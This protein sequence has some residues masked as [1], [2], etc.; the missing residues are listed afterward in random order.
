MILRFHHGWGFD[1]AFWRGVAALLPGYKLEY[2]DRGYFGEPSSP[3]P[4][5]E[6]LIAV[7]HSFGTMI[8]L[9]EP[10]ST[11][12][13]LIAFNGFDCFT[14]RKDM[15]AT[16]SRILDRMLARLSA[17]PDAVLSE[18]R[19]RC[20]DETIFARSVAEPLRRDLIALRDWDCR[21]Q[22]AIFDMPILSLQ[23]G[24]DP[25]LSPA[26]RQST[27]ASARQLEREELA[28]AGH[29]LP[30]TEPGICASR[31]ADFAEHLR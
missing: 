25:I 3:P 26:M 7:A 10:M 18:F 19:E 23:G 31:I 24:S 22:T 8:A 29:L 12:Q 14:A 9:R 11:C 13:R 28:G 20:G 4:A 30:L 5:D 16:P 27:L 1:A 15:Q 6:P 21:D 17:D 2:C